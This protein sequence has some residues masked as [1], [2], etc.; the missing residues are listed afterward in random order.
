ML[1][2]FVFAILPFGLL[3]QMRTDP[4]RKN[5]LRDANSYWIEREPSTGS[6]SSMRNQF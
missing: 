3:L 1:V 5:R 2:L 6:L 4:L